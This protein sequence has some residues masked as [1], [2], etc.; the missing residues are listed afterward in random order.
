MPCPNLPSYPK[1]DLA[2]LLKERRA[3]VI[4]LDNTSLL[5]RKSQPFPQI[6]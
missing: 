3:K 2:L 6:F 5:I 4:V 1:L